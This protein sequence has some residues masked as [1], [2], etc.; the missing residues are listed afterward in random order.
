MTPNSN[1]EFEI[2]LKV[3]VQEK[4]AVN[5]V[6]LLVKFTSAVNRIIVALNIRDMFAL[7]VMWVCRLIGPNLTSFC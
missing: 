4:Q 7:D 2:G 1:S 6:S 3:L 5:I